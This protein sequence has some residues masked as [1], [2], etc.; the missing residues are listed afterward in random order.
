MAVIKQ[1]VSYDMKYRDIPISIL[2]S[3]PLDTNITI[4]LEF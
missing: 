1:N 4:Y 3:E 2:I